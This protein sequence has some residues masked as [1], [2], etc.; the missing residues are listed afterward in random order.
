[1]SIINSV[2][3]LIQKILSDEA[4]CDEIIDELIK[5]K[6][7]SNRRSALLFLLES[8][9]TNQNNS[10]VVFP[11]AYYTPE[12]EDLEDNGDYSWEGINDEFIEELKNE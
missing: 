6:I 10:N 9:L 4:N 3:E 8:I 7:F 12:E 5:E 1:M 11:I 2:P